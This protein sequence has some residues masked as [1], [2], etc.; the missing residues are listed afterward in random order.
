M[1]LSILNFP[2]GAAE[3]TS[4]LAGDRT[5]FETAQSGTLDVSSLVSGTDYDATLK[6]V[7][8]G[9]ALSFDGSK[10]VR[11]G[12]VSEVQAITITGAPT[13]G[14]F[15]ITFDGE[16]TAAIAY[17]ATA[18]TVQA[19]L[20][21]LSNV[22]PGDITVGGAA[23]AWTLTFGGRYAEQS[24]PQVT[25][26]SSLTGGADPAVT[27]STTTAGVSGVLAGFLAK[28]EPLIREDGATSTSVIIAV[29]KEGVIN[30]ERLPVAAHRSI[31]QNTPT[32][33]AF[34]FNK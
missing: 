26:A 33:G 27:P 14:T 4:W 12:G 23:G 19:A 7:P 6:V 13:G 24:V 34:A 5:A 16:T 31:D 32:T 11:F 2:G 3:D 1:D 17:N 22:N 28:N 8:S 20:E 18:A 21:A 29:V 25:A 15:T 10:Y 30:S 9:L